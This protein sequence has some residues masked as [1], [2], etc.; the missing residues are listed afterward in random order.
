MTYILPNNELVDRQ[1]S[2]IGYVWNRGTHYLTPCWDSQLQLLRRYSCHSTL[3]VARACAVHAAYEHGALVRRYDVAG[4]H[5][6]CKEAGVARRDA[7]AGLPSK[8]TAGSKTTMETTIKRST[9]SMTSSTTKSN[10]IGVRPHA[11]EIS[12]RRRRRRR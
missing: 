1:S 12:T 5:R 4:R 3:H 11:D 6:W 9:T 8:R 10:Q 7:A 2:S